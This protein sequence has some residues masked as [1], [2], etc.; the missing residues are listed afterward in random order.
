MQSDNATTHCDVLLLGSGEAAKYL[1]WHLGSEGK[2]CVVIE[3]MWIGG[4]CPNVACLPSKNVTH[5][6]KVAHHVSRASQLGFSTG[7]EKAVPDLDTVI[8]RKKTMVV[9]DV[10]AHRDLYSQ[11]GVEVIEG[12][13]KFVDRKT[14]AVVNEQGYERTVSGDTIVVCTGSRST[15]ANIPGLRAAFPMTHVELLDLREIPDHLIVLGG[16]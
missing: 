11:G 9:E 5:S 15:I 14:I 3:K 13:G 1:A 6:A 16:E 7:I 4:S 12:T 8:E 2:R 10:G